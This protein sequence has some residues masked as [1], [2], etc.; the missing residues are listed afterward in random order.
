MA[1][2]IGFILI[3]VVFLTFIVLNLNNKC[4]ISFGF[5]EVK[6]LPVFITAFSSFVLGMLFAVPFVLSLKKKRSSPA[7]LPGGPQDEPKGLKKWVKDKPAAPDAA[8]F[9]E[10]HGEDVP[11]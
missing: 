3:F 9:E 1:R 6:D 4:D 10:L 8:G 11:R 2:L 7:V 5:T